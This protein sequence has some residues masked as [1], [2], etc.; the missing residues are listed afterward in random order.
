MSALKGTSDS[1]IALIAPFVWW[2]DTAE[3]GNLH[4][5]KDRITPGVVCV[6]GLGTEEWR[7]VIISKAAKPWCFRKSWIGKDNYRHNARAWIGYV[8]PLRL[9]CRAW[10]EHEVAG[11][12]PPPDCGQY[13]GAQNFLCWISWCN[14]F[15]DDATRACDGRL[16]ARQH[17]S[18]VQPLDIDV[19]AAFMVHVKQS[20][21][22]WRLCQHEES[23]VNADGKGFQGFTA[24]IWHERC[25]PVECCRLDGL[26]SCHSEESKY[27]TLIL[28]SE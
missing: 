5:P 3:S 26:E 20:M 19:I 28:K 14:G 16:P 17:S 2:A 22:K 4:K 10:W 9:A 13:I 21:L 12:T 6:N 1:L 18:V 8:R 11:Q 27:L 24:D 7:L 15:R 25:N 23:K